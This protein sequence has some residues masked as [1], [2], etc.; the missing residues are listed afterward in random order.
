[1][2]CVF[3]SPNALG[4]LIILTLVYIIFSYFRSK[5]PQAGSLDNDFGN[6]Q[7]PKFKLNKQITS[8]NQSHNRCSNNSKCMARLGTQIINYLQ[9][10]PFSECWRRMKLRVWFFHPCRLGQA[11][12]EPLM[13]L[14][15]C[16]TPPLN[17]AQHRTKAYK[18][19]PLLLN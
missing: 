10:V 18:L 9:V 17:T 14:Q 11:R 3:F 2:V 16:N 6:N 15:H 8:I 1:L 5:C 4:L 7:W 13:V 19:T 12:W